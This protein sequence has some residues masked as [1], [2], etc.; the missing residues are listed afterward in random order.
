[1][2]TISAMIVPLLSFHFISLAYALPCVESQKESISYHS[3][4]IKND[5]ENADMI[6]KAENNIKQFCTDKSQDKFSFER[7]SCKGIFTKDVEK[8]TDVY[9]SINL[10]KRLSTRELPDVIVFYADG[11][12]S[13]VVMK[14]GDGYFYCDAQTGI[15]LGYILGA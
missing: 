7:I 3:V 11:G 14:G 1:M 13:S 2:I 12:D 5:Q 9:F 4:Q 15:L 8:P 6:K 10:G